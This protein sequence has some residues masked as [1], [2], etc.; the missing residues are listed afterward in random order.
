[1]K[2]FLSNVIVPRCNSY[3]S[4]SACQS[5]LLLPVLIVPCCVNTQNEYFQLLK[6]VSIF[7]WTT[8]WLLG[9][10]PQ[11]KTSRFL[12]LWRY[13]WACIWFSLGSVIALSIS[14]GICQ[15]LVLFYH[16]WALVISIPNSRTYIFKN[17]FHKWE[18][19]S[20]GR[21]LFLQYLKRLFVEM[22]LANT[23][24]QNFSWYFMFLFVLSLHACFSKIT[25]DSYN[26][27]ITHSFPSLTG[28]PQ[29]SWLE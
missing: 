9:K 24:S 3:G 17:L 19:L 28:S 4:V 1:M 10:F 26:L 22:F 12:I 18:T 14:N 23:N 8:S 29:K 6:D 11:A 7:I 20:Y 5:L 25:K 21:F 15:Y 13:D 16:N 27:S 2:C